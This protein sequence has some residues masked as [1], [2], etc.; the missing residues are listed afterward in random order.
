MYKENFTRTSKHLRYENT[1]DVCIQERKHF[2]FILIFVSAIILLLT[3]YT[4]GISLA[5]T[6]TSTDIFKFQVKV[7]T[8]GHFD[9]RTGELLQGI[10]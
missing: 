3:S 4:I 6:T 7:S 8:R 10:I 1:C 2:K 5:Q 9:P